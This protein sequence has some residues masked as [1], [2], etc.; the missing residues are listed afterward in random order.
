MPKVSV[1]IPVYGVEKYISRCLDSVISQTLNDIEIVIVND[2]TPD[3]SM[4]IVQNYAAKDSRI[5]IVEH[6]VNKGLMM[7]RRTGYMAATGDYI[8]FCDSDDTLAED[9]L[10]ALYSTAEKEYADIV[11]GT[12][13]YISNNGECYL[14]TNTL[15]Y[16]TDK[17]SVFKSLLKDEFGHN[18]CSRLFRRELLQT[19]QYITFERATNGEDGMLFYQ[20]IDNTTKIIAI[21]NIVYKYYQN[22]ASSSNVRLG[23]NALRCISQGNLLRKEITGKYPE[24]LLYRDKKISSVYWDLFAKGYNIRPIFCEYGL[25]E[26]VKVNSLFKYLNFSDVVKV[27]VKIFIN[28]FLS[29]S[30]KN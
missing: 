19:G 3:K 30:R 24:L 21:D 29:Q 6:E 17:I 22:M 14:W 4:E 28:R 12:I 1:C 11:S 10:N 9:A 26:Y 7:A 23:D 27:T 8:T 16:G 5:K 18:L 20:V 2:C 25:C 13:Q 15:K